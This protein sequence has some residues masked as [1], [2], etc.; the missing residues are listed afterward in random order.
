MVSLV[1]LL[2]SAISAGTYLAAKRALGE[3]SPFELALARFTLAGLVFALLLWRWRV[4]F[5]PRDLLGLALLGFVAVPLNQG[6]FL[7]GLSLSTPSHAALL[8]ALTPVFVLLLA[9]LR[10]GERASA[11]K[12]IGI[13]LA[14][15]GVAIVLGARGSPQPGA[16]SRAL[17][18]DVLVLLAV[19]AWAAFV[20]GGK[21][22]AERYGPI[23]AT[24]A[25]LLAGTILYLPIGLPLSDLSRFTRLSPTGWAT[26]AYLVALTSV[27]AYLLFY[28]A[29]SRAE[30]SRIA[31]WSNLQPVLTAVLA[32]WLFG[33]RLTAPFLAGGAMV[34]AGVALTQRG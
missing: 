4:R 19:A 28:W 25:A 8:Y 23:P 26:V 16:P 2:H 3:L 10:L 29:L 13:A 15:A 9:R 30:A 34:L 24:S 14:F 7:A 31:V 20:V 17:L 21:P 1:M 11:A 18:G 32:W 6:L 33:E 27:V 5:D 22:Y 12:A